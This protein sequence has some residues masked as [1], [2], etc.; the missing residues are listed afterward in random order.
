MKSITLE[1][2]YWLTGYYDDFHSSV[3]VADDGN[4]ASVRTISHANSHFGSLLNGE[5]ILN[6]RFKH[7]YYDRLRSGQYH[8]NDPIFNLN[9]DFFT[10]DDNKL[11]M[12]RGLHEWITVDI[13]NNDGS[14]PELQTFLSM[15][16]TLA[17]NR[18]KWNGSGSEGYL[19]F[20]NPHDSAG[21]YYMPTG[22]IDPTLGGD[23]HFTPKG[24]GLPAL[25]LEHA[26][27][28]S[29]LVYSNL[30]GEIKMTSFAGVYT[31]EEAQAGY[32]T[33]N[34]RPQKLPARS[35]VAIGSKLSYQFTV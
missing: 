17:A 24:T 29:R 20:A 15:P 28:Y 35:A 18:H 5:N 9:Y 21:S 27:G 10:D 31:G 25:N 34:T 2:T 11:A 7:S 16:T 22:T 19:R 4:E 8:E 26:G 23:R 1:Q 33:A 14:N 30:E 12:N 3:A 6:P 32:N 13:T